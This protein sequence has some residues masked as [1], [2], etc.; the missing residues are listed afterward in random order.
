MKIELDNITLGHSPLT[1]SVF[2]GITSSPGKWRQK[3]DVTN[4]FIG[5]VIS[6]W[7]NQKEV[8]SS[9]KNKWEITV[10]KLK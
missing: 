10:K 3:K 4:E 1:D 2:A 7:E 5:C 9:G 6:R 8:I